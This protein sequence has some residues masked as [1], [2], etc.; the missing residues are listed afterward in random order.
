MSHSVQ[1]D[2]VLS[3]GINT[4][5]LTRETRRNTQSMMKLRRQDFLHL[6]TCTDCLR[7]HKPEGRKEAKELAKAA[8]ARVWARLVMVSSA[9]KRH[10][11]EAKRPTNI[12]RDF[13]PY[14]RERGLIVI[15]FVI[16]QSLSLT[17]SSLLFLF[18]SLKRHYYAKTAR[19]I[20]QTR[21]LHKTRTGNTNLNFSPS[22]YVLS[23]AK[24]L[25][26]KWRV[27][28]TYITRLNLSMILKW[29]N[30]WRTSTSEYAG[31]TLFMFRS[32]WLGFD[33]IF[34]KK[35]TNSY[36]TICSLIYP[37]SPTWVYLERRVFL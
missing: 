24:T 14:L 33:T 4:F 5:S 31:R 17:L 21:L 35:R 16:A 29:I 1:L 27:S 30:D 9:F 22:T 10:K 32:R 26:F 11:S 3:F 23:Q 12:W 34:Y 7:N 15:I 37:T 8:K 13:Y 20:F 19:K 18:F 2:L 25:F 28:K 6:G 36:K